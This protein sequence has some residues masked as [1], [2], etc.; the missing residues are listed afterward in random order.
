[1]SVKV[2]DCLKTVAT[3]GA[4]H[5]L[6]AGIKLYLGRGKMILKLGANAEIDLSVNADGDIL[7]AVMDKEV[8]SDQGG[9]IALHPAA[10]SAALVK[11]AGGNA[12]IAAIIS[13]AVPALVALLPKQ[14]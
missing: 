14:P 11:L 10:V 4:I 12:T 13:Y 6:V 7:V 2:I 1:M 9:Q 8:L 3:L 5:L